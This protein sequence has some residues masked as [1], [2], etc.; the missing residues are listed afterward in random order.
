MSRIVVVGAGVIGLACAYSLRKRGRDVIVLD[1]GQPGGACSK[2]NAGWIT[3]S[4][5][6]PIPAPGLMLASLRWMLQSDSPLYISPSAV[7]ALARW[8]W[9]FWRYCNPRD[10]LHGLRAV[11]ELNRKTLSAFDEL[12][13]DGFQFELHRSG[14]LC[15][16]L[17]ERH[18][19]RALAE[20]GHYREY[21]YRMPTAVHGSDLTRLEPALSGGSRPVSWSRKSSTSGRRRW[22]R[23]MW[24]GS[25][26]WASRFGRM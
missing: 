15:V 4:I 11:S 8:L 6:A 16:F 20:F 26:S 21:G 22:S 1:M 5:S 19:M 17:D 2:G 7:P 12:E 14:M 24:I 13:R 10:F 18:M 25:A 9:R 3:P 23:V